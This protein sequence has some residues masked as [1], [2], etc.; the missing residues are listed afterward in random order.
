MAISLEPLTQSVTFTARSLIDKI[1][2]TFVDLPDSRRTTTSNNLKYTIEEAALSAFAVFLTPSP[3]FLD[4]QVR[5]QKARGKSN[6]DSIFGVHQ[7]PSANPIRNILD[8]VPVE[9]VYPLLA[10]ISN[11]LYQNGYLTS[12]RSINE[13]RL[14][15]I[16]GTHFFSSQKI[17]C[18]GC[19]QQTLKNGGTSYYHSAVTPVIVAPGQ[20]EVVPLPAE[21]VQPQDGYQQPDCELAA[22]KRWLN[23]WGEY[24]APWKVTILGD[25]L[26]CH[27][28]FCQNAIDR[29]FEVLLVCKPD[30]HPLLY[31]WIADFERT[32]PV[33]TMKRIRWNGRQHLT[34]CYRY[35][36][37]V[38]LRDSD[39]ALMLNW[40]ELIITDADGKVVY[41]NSWATTHPIG[42][43]HVVKIANAAR[44]RWKIENENNNVLKKRGYHFEHNFGHGKQHLS[45]W[46]ATLIWLAYLFHTALDWIDAVYRTVRSRL[47]SR[48]TF[49]EHLR[50]LMPYL[51]FENWEHLMN[52]M[53]NGL[54]IEIPDS[55]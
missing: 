45:N 21:F 30:S 33:R 28:P 47:S 46:L 24:Y 16:D 32:R 35:M 22:A 50:A 36:N 9:T 52:F 40:G 29:G 37:Q 15:P 2:S 49:F 4:Y 55:S 5:M 43:N 10:E 14:M 39:D 27:Q 38:P 11:D 53:L 20:S 23:T 1:K 6:M 41:Q 34:E 51:L 19:S 3:S 18:P 13:T 12:F 54:E 17:S 44:A 7:I 25:D 42:D 26:Y 48:R 31:E 8:S